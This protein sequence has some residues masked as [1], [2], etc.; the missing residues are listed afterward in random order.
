MTR[1]EVRKKFSEIA[2]FAEIDDFLDTPVKRY[3]TGM[4]MRLGFAVAAHLDAEILIVDE[5][6]AVGDLAFQRKCLGK[7]SQVARD[8][9][10]VLF[11]SHHT[12]T[13]NSLCARA[14][15]LD[16]G[17]VAID[18]LTDQVLQ[19]Y[20][21][22][23]I[24]AGH[25]EQLA[26]RADRTGDGRIRFV[27]VLWENAA[28]ER[29]PFLRSGQDCRL[30]LR[31]RCA[32]G[33][34]PRMPVVVSFALL[35]ANGQVIVNHRNDFTAELFENVSRTG[36]FVCCIPRLPLAD[37]N[38]SL[39]LFIGTAGRPCDS[40]ADAA[41]VIVERGDFFRTGHGGDPAFCKTLLDASWGCRC[42]DGVA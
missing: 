1:A 23:R 9:R 41:S 13:V 12:G 16:K 42:L 18:G 40:I 2:A 30:V 37:G 3:S 15:L 27:E 31:Y 8:G 32:A 21:N 35:D 14:I 20:Q 22:A 6:L 17:A 34:P 5:V 36:A 28:G 11:V 10:T 38:Y 39:N 4:Q 33:G 7:M 19:L 29:L 26:D 25:V 24:G